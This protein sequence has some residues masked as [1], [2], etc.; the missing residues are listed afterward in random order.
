MQYEDKENNENETKEGTNEE[1]KKDSAEEEQI[2]K[3]AA[4]NALLLSIP[5]IDSS[6]NNNNN[7]DEEEP[8]E[9]WTTSRKRNCL[10]RS[11]P[12]APH[13]KEL[14]DQSHR[15]LLKK[16]SQSNFSDLLEIKNDLPPSLSSQIT[17][18]SSSRLLDYFDTP[19]KPSPP[20]P[21]KPS[22]P[23]PLSSSAIS[24]DNL[25]LLIEEYSNNNT[26]DNNNDNNNDNID[27]EEANH[28]HDNDTNNNNDNNDN[29]NDN[30]NN[31]I[32]N[33]VKEENKEE[34]PTRKIMQLN[35]TNDS[36]NEEL[37]EELSLN[38]HENI[39]LGIITG[40]IGAVGEFLQTINDEEANSYVANLES[41]YASYFAD[42]DE[43]SQSVIESDSP[44]SH[45]IDDLLAD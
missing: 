43:F 19:P 28:E 20:L 44:R 41:K 31:E 12:I 36:E 23:S 30:D 29:N 3:E 26:N 32:E 27:K 34:V 21:P 33:E 25:S 4:G 15:Q 5:K 18:L 45:Q 1:I 14:K 7:N 8:K 37:I 42:F 16:L 17:K 35:V 6:N 11:M 22:P 10:T 24:V 39:V 9:G 40:H 13:R 38:E 2:K